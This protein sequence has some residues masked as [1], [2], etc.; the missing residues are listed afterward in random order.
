MKKYLVRYSLLG[1]LAVIIFQI[2]NTLIAAGSFKNIRPQFNGTVEKISLPVSGPEDITIDTANGLAFISCDDRRSNQKNAGSVPGAILVM[3]LND[4]SKT[5]RNITPNELNDFHP[6]GISLFKTHDGKTILFAI[7]HRSIEPK[8][9][10]ERFEWRNDSLYHLETIAGPELMTSPNDL[11]ATGERTFYVTNDHYYP[12]PGIG[13]TLEEYLQRAISYVN[14]YDGNTFRKVA[15]QIPYSNGIQVSPDGSKVYVASIIGRNVL[16]Y[17]RGNDNALSLQKKINVSTGADNIELD[18]NGDLLVGCHPQLL[19]FVAHAKDPAK[20]SPSQIL[21]IKSS[22]HTVEE[23]FLNDG[24][25]YSGS[26]VA[27]PFRGIFLVGSVFEPSL[28]ILKPD[29]Q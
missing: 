3:N 13:R 10:V 1:V 12:D 18:S 25:E 9:V 23:L 19:K 6:H 5:I 26:T 27:A 17:D 15:D 29:R 28:L 8:H 4:S 14:Y 16:V 21:R 7:S 20:F 24:K 22:D 2:I 11:S